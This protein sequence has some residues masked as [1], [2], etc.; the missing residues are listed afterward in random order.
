MI[1]AKN[2]KSVLVGL[3]G[4]GVVNQAVFNNMEN[5]IKK[6][7]VIYSLEPKYSNNFKKTLETDVVIITIPTNY[8]PD[9][10]DTETL[11]TKK[12]NFKKFGSSKSL[13][14]LVKILYNYYSNNYTGLIIIKSTCNPKLLNKYLKEKYNITLDNFEII[15]WPEFLNAR[16]AN[17]DFE[18]EIPLLGGDAKIIWKAIPLLIIIFKKSFEK[19]NTGTF[20][21]VMEY[22]YFRNM[23]LMN[24]FA[25]INTIPTLFDTDIR[26]FDELQKE[27]S[28]DFN[29]FKIASDGRLGVNGACLPKDLNNFIQSN[30]NLQ[31]KK[32][33]ELDDNRNA[34]EFLK[35]ISSYN[36]NLQNV[37]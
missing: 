33:F 10:R 28:Y 15:F 11:I 6:D 25:F 18:K 24:H 1:P 14:A 2:T 9:E 23:I 16:T 19:Y 21:E 17:Q 34:I 3:V 36:T 20:Q 31:D 37:K 13:K 4:F 7:V 35:N 8:I 29:T 26:K 30:Y 27:Y 12:N 32:Y 5:Y 22:K